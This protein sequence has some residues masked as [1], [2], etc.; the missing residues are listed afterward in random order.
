MENKRRCVTFNNKG[1]C[2]HC[3]HDCHFSKVDT[4]N[5]I[6]MLK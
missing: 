5:V 2:H 3:Q 6:I 4:V 1:K